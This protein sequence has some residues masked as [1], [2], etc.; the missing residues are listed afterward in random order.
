MQ[1][2][3]GIQYR[4]DID[5]LRALAVL[6]VFAYHLQPA[7]LPAGGL[8]VDIFFVISG[9]LIGGI[10][11]RESMGGTFSFLRF[12]ERRLRR[13][14][15][16]LLVS[17]A[18]VLIAST[19][20][21]MPDE[22][23]DGSISAVAAILS[24]SNLYFWQTTNYFNPAAADMPL[25]HTWSLGVEEQFYIVAP[26]IL[27]LLIQY[28]RRALMPALMVMLAVS[29]ALN[30]MQV[31]HAPVDAFYLPQGRAWELLTG[32]VLNRLTL[33]LLK[34]R[35]ARECAAGL[36]VA[37]LAL[38][39]ALLR[40]KL[41]WPGL[42][43]VPPVMGTALILWAGQHGSSSIARMLSFKPV[44]F[45]GLISYSL[46][47]WHWPAIVFAREIM[48][49]EQLSN[50]Q[51][52]A[53][54]VFAFIAAWLSWR[55]VEQPF[56]NPATMPGRKLVLST[57]GGTVLLLCACIFI[58]IGKG[59]PARYDAETVRI[60]SFA[61]GVPD[62]PWR[63]CILTERDSLAAFPAD[64]LSAPPP[65]KRSILLLG[66]SHA[67]MFRPALDDM[68]DASIME[69]TYAA[70]APDDALAPEAAPTPC[71]QLVRKA[72]AV[73]E[74]AR[75][76]LIILS[77]QIKRL[78]PD[79]VRALGKRLKQIGSSV[80][81]IGPTPDYSVRVPKLLAAARVRDEPELPARFMRRHLWHAD[82]QLRQLAGEFATYIS[83]RTT[84]CNGK[85][86]A[87][88]VGKDPA[89]YDRQHF[90]GNGARAIFRQM[91]HQ[92]LTSDQRAHLGFRT[93]E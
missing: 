60:A 43:A 73:A 72:L 86:C 8:G 1:H 31:S 64:C 54:I 3:G 74:Q 15:P 24:A 33:P 89:Y 29:L 34:A 6:S 21:L 68:T 25:L 16:A 49:A 57:G 75:P 91:L 17:V 83:P 12:Y 79:R 18:A 23:K 9:Y 2:S 50:R 35:W 63:R 32:V 4:P 44:T 20:L 90:N 42:A 87:L 5:G 22:L 26:V 48:L 28:A 88:M 84:M 39:F 41:G 19:A 66:D 92:Q 27:T 37:L 53:V 56:R 52:L 13:I 47:L 46:Y 70:C 55:Y 14:A 51:M 10:I 11:L 82:T 30:I 65:G 45:V 93:S 85:A 61:T 67:N 36:G 7:L 77:W 38:S 80:L 78:R 62:A 58:V 71:G 69:A 76:D 59:L 40:P 81:V